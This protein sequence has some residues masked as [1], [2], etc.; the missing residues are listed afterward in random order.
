[1]AIG[2]MQ[3]FAALCYHLNIVDGHPCEVFARAV[4]AH[5]ETRRDRIRADPRDALL[6]PSIWHV[7]RWWNEVS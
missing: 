6:P 2:T 4:R 3:E 1:V 5:D 7:I